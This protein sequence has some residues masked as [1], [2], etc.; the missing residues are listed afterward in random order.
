[1][2]T[3]GGNI[4]NIDVTGYVHHSQF[5]AGVD[6]GAD[7]SFGGTNGNGDNYVAGASVGNVTITGIF[8]GSDL[9]ASALPSTAKATYGNQIPNVDVNVGAG[10]SIGTV[11]IDT[12]GASGPGPFGFIQAWQNSGETNAIEAATIA[13]ASVNGL[14]IAIASPGSEI[15]WGAGTSFVAGADIAVREII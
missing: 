3:T 6:L 14:G 7:F 4:G 10:G 1:M 8:L 15:H 12:A 13:S 11:R 2:F 5:L 9:V